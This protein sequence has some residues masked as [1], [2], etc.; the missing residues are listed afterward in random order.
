MSALTGDPRLMSY[1]YSIF[2]IQQIQ[3]SVIDVRKLIY[4]GR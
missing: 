2:L 3:Q 4:S 1:G